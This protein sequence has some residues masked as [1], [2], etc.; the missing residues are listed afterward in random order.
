MP[1]SQF[2][3]QKFLARHKSW[4]VWVTNFIP[5]FVCQVQ[6]DV[7]SILASSSLRPQTHLYE[8]LRKARW[9]PTSNLMSFPHQVFYPSFTSLSYTFLPQCFEINFD[10]ISNTIHKTYIPRVK[11]YASRISKMCCMKSL[12]VGNWRV[13]LGS[14]ANSDQFAKIW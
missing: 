4:V 3:W 7:S 5:Q 13:V 1:S 14:T 6:R 8:Q 10:K 9:V 11:Q 2:F 12:Q